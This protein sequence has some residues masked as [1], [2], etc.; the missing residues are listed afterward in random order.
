LNGSE[1]SMFS[2]DVATN[3]NTHF[4]ISGITI[5][6]NRF[7]QSIQISSTSE[8]IKEFEVYNN[9]GQIVHADKP[10]SKW[11]S[12]KTVGLKEGIY[13]FIF[14]TKQARTVKKYMID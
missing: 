13:F 4:E 11:V 3:V 2:L 5:K 8:S 1:M 14:K 7:E 12:I 9:M 6:Y 10:H